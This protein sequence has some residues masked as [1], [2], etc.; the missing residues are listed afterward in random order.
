MGVGLSAGQLGSGDELKAVCA[1]NR[2]RNLTPA[3]RSSAWR[4]NSWSWYGSG[5]QNIL[6]PPEAS[7]R[8]PRRSFC[9]RFISAEDNSLS[10][11]W[12]WRRRVWVNPP[13]GNGIGN[14]VEKAYRSA[15]VI[16]DREYC[17]HVVMLLPA[18]TDTQWFH[19]YCLKASEIRFLRGRLCFGDDRAKRAPFPSSSFERRPDDP[20]QA[21]D[22]YADPPARSFADEPKLG[23]LVCII[24]LTLSAPLRRS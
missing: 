23:R 17:E 7:A 21:R 14:W 1:Q 20:N 9:D 16:G 8:S 10:E 13:Y 19:D 15:I 18:R 2:V 12:A 11:Q 6:E 4:T 5:A 22:L 24:A 3:V